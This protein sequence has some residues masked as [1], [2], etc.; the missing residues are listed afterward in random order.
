MAVS[1]TLNFL[2]F[3]FHEHCAHVIYML[4]TTPEHR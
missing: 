1:L 3:E 4:F 2:Y